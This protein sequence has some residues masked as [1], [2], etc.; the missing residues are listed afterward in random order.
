MKLSA[1][2]AGLILIWNF[3]T[4]KGA[5]KKS[6]LFLLHLGPNWPSFLQLQTQTVVEFSFNL[7]PRFVLLILFIHLPPFS[8][9]AATIRCS[10]LS[11]YWLANPF[12]S[13]H[14]FDSISHSLAHSNT[15]NDNNNNNNESVKNESAELKQRKAGK[16]TRRLNYGR[17]PE[18]CT[19]CLTN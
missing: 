16:E 6:P 19:I 10:C 4:E 2:F 15:D 3:V 5:K 8:Y 14:S 18:V 17:Q 11:I 13:I 7:C 9:L 1:D 12:N